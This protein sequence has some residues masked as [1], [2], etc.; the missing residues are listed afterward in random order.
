MDNFKNHIKPFGLINKAPEKDP[1]A[2]K[3]IKPDGTKVIEQQTPLGLTVYEVNPKG[4]LISR[5]YDHENK[6]ILDYARKGN[7]EIGH[8]YDEFGR[9]TYEFT[10]LYDE[11]NKFAKRTEIQYEY[12]QNDVK[13][14]EFIVNTPGVVQTEILYDPDGIRIDKIEHRGTVKTFFDIN[15]KPYK[16]E[17]DRG[18]GGIITE[19]L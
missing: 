5:S 6:L 17:I 14:R 12:H 2:P 15:D 10:T 19:E 13:S 1:M 3:Y 4:L 16:R 7:T 11:H 8:S 9:K 18:S